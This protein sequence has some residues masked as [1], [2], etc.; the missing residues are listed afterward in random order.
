MVKATS[1]DR[2]CDSGLSRV[3]SI[4]PRRNFSP[5]PHTEK[6]ANHFKNKTGTSIIESKTFSILFLVFAQSFKGLIWK[7][8]VWTI[9]TNWTNMPTYL[10]FRSSVVKDC[11]FEITARQKEKGIQMCQNTVHKKGIWE[12]INIQKICTLY[13]ISATPLVQH[14][15]QQVP[16]FSEFKVSDAVCTNSI[17]LGL[18]WDRR[19][20]TL[21][22]RLLLLLLLLR[23]HYKRWDWQT[24]FE[25]GYLLKTDS[26]SRYVMLE[27]RREDRVNTEFSS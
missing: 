26:A 27:T 10:G 25:R 11:G 9:W 7:L 13:Y 17:Q 16:S 22:L 12:P 23:D 15:I 5:L 21:R 18:T 3:K 8:W 20:L 6:R 1:R 4:F 14:K 24:S 2:A 19:G